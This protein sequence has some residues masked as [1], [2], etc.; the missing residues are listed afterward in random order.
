MQDTPRPIPGRIS[1]APERP[2]I[3]PVGSIQERRE[4][5]VQRIKVPSLDLLFCV[6]SHLVQGAEWSSLSLRRKTQEEA[7]RE[8]NYDTHLYMK[9]TIPGGQKTHETHN[10]TEN[11]CAKGTPYI[12][13]HLKTNL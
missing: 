3:Q 11:R 7:S 2:D 8:K 13:S 6:A 1:Y 10:N 12:L 5:E 4:H 9:T